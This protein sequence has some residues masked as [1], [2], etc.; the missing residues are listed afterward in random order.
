MAIDD[1]VV[2]AMQPGERHAITELAVA[3]RADYD[4]VFFALSR[5]CEWGF[6]QADNDNYWSLTEFGEQLREILARRI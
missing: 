6:T 4:R 3:I 5:L 2:V 1:Q